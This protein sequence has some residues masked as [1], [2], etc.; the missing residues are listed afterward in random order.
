MKNTENK[1]LD[2]KDLASKLLEGICRVTVELFD[3]KVTHKEMDF[4]NCDGFP[5]DVLRNMW[6]AD[7]IA[8][9]TEIDSDILYQLANEEATGDES[10]E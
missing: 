1:E 5:L 6:T 3:H 9:K 4:E 8:K 7:Y 2:Y 10:D